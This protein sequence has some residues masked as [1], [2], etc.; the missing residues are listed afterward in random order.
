MKSSNCFANQGTRCR[1]L[2]KMLCNSR[3]CSFY[4]TAEQ[5]K[6]DLEKYPPIDYMEQYKSKHKNDE[7]RKNE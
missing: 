2:T 4:K 5:Q 3:K 7:V 1:V 6:A